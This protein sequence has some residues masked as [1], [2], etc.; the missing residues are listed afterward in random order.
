M[1]QREVGG[2][3]KES[4]YQE[5]GEGDQETCRWLARMTKG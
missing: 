4:G 5:L 3:G 1:R 2:P